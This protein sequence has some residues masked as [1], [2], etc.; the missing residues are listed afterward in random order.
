M[1]AAELTLS[2]VTLASSARSV[3]DF[4]DVAPGR[5]KWDIRR[6][7]CAFLLLIRSLVP[8]RYIVWCRGSLAVTTYVS[9]RDVTDANWQ[10]VKYMLN[11]NF[12]CF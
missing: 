7:F 9:S 5:V 3:S 2:V 4:S 1:R 6:C 8:I 11:G 12:S 10:L